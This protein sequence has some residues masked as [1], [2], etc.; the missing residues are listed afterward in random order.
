[1]PLPQQIR[2]IIFTEIVPQLTPEIESMSLVK[3]GAIVRQKAIANKYEPLTD[4]LRKIQ[5]VKLNGLKAVALEERFAKQSEKGAI[6]TADPVILIEHR[7]QV[8]DCV[9]HTKSAL[10]SMAVFL[11]DLLELN[12]KEGDRDLKKGKFRESIAQKDTK[13]GE[14]VH[15]LEPWLNELQRIRDEWIHIRSIRTAIVQGP[16]E[17]GIFPIPKDVTLELKAFELPCTKENFWSTKDF[18]NYHYSNSVRLFQGI[19]DRSI[20]L[21]E[22][23]LPTPVQV[24][25]DEKN[26]MFWPIFVTQN[27]T[28][29]KMKVY[30]GD[31][32][33]ES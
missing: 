6:Q 10:D 17:V 11:T 14:L 29:N 22:K 31:R 12:A 23:G 7:L 2:G 1:M 33:P 4:S 9:I 5:W 25:D 20:E 3:L 30:F 18:V 27:M 21:E 32:Q 26:L 24:P 13:L 19:V 8:T 28:V 16:S 15:A